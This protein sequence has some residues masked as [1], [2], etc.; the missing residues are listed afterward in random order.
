MKTCFKCQVEKPLSEYYA[1]KQ[2]ADGKLNKCKDC[3]KKD[4]KNRLL[5][6]LQD[7]DFF[8]REQSRH[9]DKYHRLGYREKHKPTTEAKKA[10]C[11]SYKERYPGKIF[12]KSKLGKSPIGFHFHHWSY[13]KEHQKDVILIRHAD[14]YTL[15]R[16][17]DYYQ[18]EMCYKTKSGVLLDTKEKHIQHIQDIFSL[19][20]IEKYI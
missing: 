9:R 1:H 6:K 11:N 3:T 20:G 16:F 15:H 5:L 4:T 7:P 13:K 14:H 8:E 12:A 19:N 2:M 18:P 10:I 17:I